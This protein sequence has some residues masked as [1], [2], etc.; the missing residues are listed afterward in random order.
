MSESGMKRRL[1]QKVGHGS[2]HAV[3]FKSVRH[4]LFPIHPNGSINR[5]RHSEKISKPDSTCV[6]VIAITQSTSKESPFPMRLRKRDLSRRVN[7]DLAIPF[8][9][10]R[11]TSYTDLKL[12]MRHLRQVDLNSRLRTA[13]GSI[14]LRWDFPWVAISDI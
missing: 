4:I 11:L 1:T 5:G 6:F 3:I 7:G 9:D 14:S 12:L 10:E 13:F 2:L 8:G